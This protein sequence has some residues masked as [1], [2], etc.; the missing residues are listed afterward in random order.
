MMLIGGS[1][2]TEGTLRFKSRF[3]QRLPKNFRLSQS[4]WLSSIGIGTYLGEPNAE[5]DRLYR[6]AILRAVQLGVNV[7]DT[8]IN[9]RHMRSE[10]NVGEALRELMAKGEIRRDEVMVATKGGFF[11]FEGE[12]PSDPAKY[13]EERFIRAGLVERE[14]IAAGCH[15]MSPR[16]LAHQLETSRHNL[17]LETIDLYYIHNPETQLHEVGHEEFYRRLEKAFEVLE[18]AAMEGKIRRYGLAT[19]NAFRVMPDSPDAVS[20]ERVVEVARRVGGKE[21]HFRAVQAPLNLAMTEA[22]QTRTQRLDGRRVSLLEAAQGFGL[23]VFLS[24]SLLQ[25]RLI[26]NLPEPLAQHF[27]GVE[28]DAQRALQFARSAPG[29]TAA[30]VGM[31]R[32]NHVAENLTTATVPPLTPQEFAAVFEE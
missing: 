27:A 12:V 32:V 26:G 28:T 11:A 22:F 23:M 3:D 13:F 20:L 17:G 21:H 15:A 30:L 2:T 14:E 10:R 8:A 16:Y 9:Y 19:W 31:S 24:A 6:E 5:Y 7:V 29:V 25:S 1:A 18:R 4:L